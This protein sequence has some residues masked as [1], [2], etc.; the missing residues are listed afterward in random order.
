MSIFVVLVANGES[1]VHA[2]SRAKQVFTAAIDRTI[3][4]AGDLMQKITFQRDTVYPSDVPVDVEYCL[5]QLDRSPEKFSVDGP[6]KYIWNEFEPQIYIFFGAAQSVK[7]A[8]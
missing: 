6:A 2:F 3:S 1:P 7:E 5:S 8:G 4:T